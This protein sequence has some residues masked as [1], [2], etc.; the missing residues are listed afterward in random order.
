MGAP[1]LVKVPA[2]TTAGAA[3][4][5]VF[6]KL[7]LLASVV[8]DASVAPCAAVSCGSG[9]LGRTTRPWP[10][11]QADRYAVVATTSVVREKMFK[12]SPAGVGVGRDAGRQ[13]AGCVKFVNLL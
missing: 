10:P 11:P 2:A 1:A 7:K 6:A 9:S 12:G 4:K 13:D 8:Q 5:E 3:V